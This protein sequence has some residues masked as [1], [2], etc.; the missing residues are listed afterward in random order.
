MHGPHYGWYAACRGR[1]ASLPVAPTIQI[2]FIFILSRPL[3]MRPWLWHVIRALHWLAPKIR[4]NFTAFLFFPAIDSSCFRVCR[5]TASVL[6]GERGAF[7]LTTN[8]HS[9]LQILRLTSLRFHELQS[10]SAIAPPVHLLCCCRKHLDYRVLP[11]GNQ[12]PPPN[13]RN[14]FFGGS[15]R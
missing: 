13:W 10:E 15:H 4:A 12:R 2:F 8:W 14:L 5:L 3:G 9:V 6:I 1:T 7:S 11:S